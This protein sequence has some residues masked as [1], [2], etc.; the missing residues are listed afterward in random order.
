MSLFLQFV[1]EVAVHELPVVE[2][3]AHVYLF[4]FLDLPLG[5]DVGLILPSSRELPID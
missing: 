4:S 5:L 2:P 3:I 1:G